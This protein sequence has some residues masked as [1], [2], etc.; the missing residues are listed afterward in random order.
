[1][2]Q[3]LSVFLAIVVAATI[4]HDFIV[5]STAPSWA[6]SEPGYQISR[7][8]ENSAE[9]SDVLQLYAHDALRELEVR[10]LWRIP[11]SSQPQR[12]EK[13]LSMKAKPAQ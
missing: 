12:R 1:M 5:A 8:Y 9:R 11:S 6:L 13:V 7:V 3:F 10:C 4:Y 2:W